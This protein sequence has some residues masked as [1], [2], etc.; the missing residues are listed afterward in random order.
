MADVFVMPNIRV[1]GDQEG[2][3][4][5][6]LE[7]GAYNL[8]VVASNLEGI[9]DAVLDGKTG[10]LVPER[11]ADSYLEAIQALT[12]APLSVKDEV[13]ANFDCN[14]IVKVYRSE[15]ERMCGSNK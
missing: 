5:V 15:F 3:G 7:A 9:K 4:I 11:D 10:R 13:L 8:P 1:D 12:E 14:H 6:L 2:F